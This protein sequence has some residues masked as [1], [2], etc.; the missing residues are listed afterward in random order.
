MVAK[1]TEDAHEKVNRTND[2]P[3]KEPKLIRERRTWGLIGWR[4]KRGIKELSPPWESK[5]GG[6]ERNPRDGKGRLC[7]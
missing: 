1:G 6:K 7:S 2:V 5:S 3:E 4:K